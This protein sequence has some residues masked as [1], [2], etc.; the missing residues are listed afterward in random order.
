MVR[1]GHRVQTEWRRPLSSVHSIMMEKSSGEGGGCMLTPFTIV[2]ITYKVAVHAPAEWA[3]TLALFHFY[4]CTLMQVKISCTGANSPTKSQKPTKKEPL[5]FVRRIR[6]FLGLL[7]PD[8][9]PDTSVKPKVCIL[10]SSSK[11][12]NKKKID[13]YRF[14]TSFSGFLSLKND[15]NVSTV[16]RGHPSLVSV[17][18]SRH[19]CKE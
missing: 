11:K 4:R 3:D 9:D 1:Y 10:L 19:P 17:I 5:S 12:I 8:P 2:T 6:M 7:Y 18:L 16:R 13:S 15:V 14:T